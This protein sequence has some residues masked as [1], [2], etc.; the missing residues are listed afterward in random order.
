MSTKRTAIRLSQAFNAICKS[1]RIDD[2]TLMSWQ[3]QIIFDQLARAV[4]DL[5]DNFDHGKF[6]DACKPGFKEP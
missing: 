2:V 5:G 6:L 3:K 1:A 4:S